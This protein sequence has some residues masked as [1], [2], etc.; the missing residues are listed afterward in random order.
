MDRLLKDAKLEHLCEQL[1]SLEINEVFSL[2][3]QGRPKLLERLKDAGVVK[4][5]ERQAVAKA[6]AV[7]RRDYFGSGQ[8][9]LL[10]LY[11]AGVPVKSGHDLM[12]PILTAAKAAGIED[13]LVLDHHNEPP[14]DKCASADEYLGM[15][16]ATIN[17]VPT[18]RNRPLVI[19]AHSHGSVAAYGLA[20]R[21]APQVRALCILARRPPTRELL[22][23][24]FGV[25]TC[26]EIARMHLAELAQ[27][28]AAVYKNEVLAAATKTPD[29]SRWGPVFVDAIRIAQAQYSSRCSLCDAA[30]IQASLGVDTPGTVPPSCVL[31]C[32]ILAVA[33]SQETEQGESES[34]MSEWRALTTNEAFRLERVDAAHMSIPTTQSVISMVVDFVKPFVKPKVFSPNPT[35]KP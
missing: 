23:D 34:K 5:P 7:L 26:P 29:T 4:L 19:V 3:D 11:S 14:Y 20:R 25:A 2:L 9:L 15:L 18:R 16:E 10:C 27:K 6:A 21:L 17:E 30:D 8:P 13:Q 28:L 22:N 1:A 35:R 12:K 31:S 32:P 33:S 24:V